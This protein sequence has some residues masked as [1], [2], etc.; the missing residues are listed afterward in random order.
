[1]QAKDLMSTNL[2]VVQPETPVL[3]VAELLA[4]R[5][6]SAVPVVDGAGAMR[7]IVTE[8][9]LIRRLADQ[10]PGP[11]GWFLQIFSKSTPLIEQFK[12]AHG[13]TAQDVMTAG[14]VSVGEEAGAEDG[15]K[16][17]GEGGPGGGGAAARGGGAGRSG[18][19]HRAGTRNISYISHI[20]VP[21]AQLR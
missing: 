16:G 18:G 9:D 6:I 11:W 15:G 20:K 19:Q 4:A 13:A 21:N 10:K 5:G 7:G 17:G 14:L 1:M 2:I 12:K 8:G 3:A